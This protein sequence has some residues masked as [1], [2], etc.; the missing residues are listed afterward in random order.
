MSDSFS[1]SKKLLDFWIDK[2]LDRIKD[3][4]KRGI[5]EW[6]GTISNIHIGGNL[7]Q[8]ATLAAGMALAQKEDTLIRNVLRGTVVTFEATKDIVPGD[9]V[10]IGENVAPIGV[11]LEAP[12]KAGNV[13]V[14]MQGLLKI[15]GDERNVGVARYISFD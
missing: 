3:K 1:N 11:A 6:S 5:R 12:D 13:K 2:P 7:I 15:N 14:L 10:S 4:P 8:E 9:I